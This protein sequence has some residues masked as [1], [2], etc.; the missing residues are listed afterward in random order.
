[1]NPLTPRQSE[2]FKYI[3][4]CI[5]KEHLP[6]TGKQLAKKFNI[7]AHAA[8][9]CFNVL[10]HKG[11]LIRIDS[12]GRNIKLTPKGLNYRRSLRNVTRVI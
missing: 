6:P 2:R 9:I 3:R 11:Y 8:Y 10:E 7:S 1:M 5:L 12:S 4:R